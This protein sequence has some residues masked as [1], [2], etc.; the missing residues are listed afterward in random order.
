MHVVCLNHIHH[1]LPSL[2]LLRLPWYNQPLPNSLLYSH[3]LLIPVSG[4]IHVW[5][6]SNTEG[7]SKQPVATPLKD[8]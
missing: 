8:K 3:N 2:L 5:V 7:L 4:P 1:P 6:W